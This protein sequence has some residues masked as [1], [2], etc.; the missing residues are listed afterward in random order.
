MLT[1]GSLS[2]SVAWSAV[3]ICPYFAISSCSLT[4]GSVHLDASLV[5][6][7]FEIRCRLDAVFFCLA[8]YVTASVLIYSPLPGLL[9]DFLDIQVVVFLVA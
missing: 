7:T 9:C 3:R 2:V 5:L 6:S 8:G 4:L 1:L